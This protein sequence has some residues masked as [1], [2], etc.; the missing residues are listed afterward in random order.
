M[1]SPEI[2]Y[3]DG[4]KYQ[5]QSAYKINLNKILKGAHHSLLLFQEPIVTD[6]ITLSA[7]GVMVIQKGYAWDGP[8]GPTI[9]T[10]S[11]MRGS[12]IHDAMYQLMRENYL[13]HGEYRETADRLLQSICVQDGMSRIRA[14]YV[15]QSVRWFADPCADPAHNK[16]ILYAP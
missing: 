13:F 5:I 1:R 10:K 14:W 7:D 3:R 9:D 12:L 11:F 6:Y 2:S 8:S 15:Y 16:P 4:Y